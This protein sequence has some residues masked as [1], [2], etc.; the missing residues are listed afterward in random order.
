MGPF[1]F[2]IVLGLVLAF[3]AGFGV[4]DGFSKKGK[5]RNK[6]LKRA[7]KAILTIQRK[8]M[9]TSGTLDIVGSTFANDLAD[10]IMDY[11]QKE[12]TK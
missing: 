8:I 5:A 1:V 7:E 4:G 6:D 9:L 2:L 10:V 3:F 12:S 11:Y